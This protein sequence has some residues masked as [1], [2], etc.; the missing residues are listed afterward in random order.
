MLACLMSLVACSDDSAEPAVPE[1]SQENQEPRTLRYLALGD[2]YTIGTGL[3]DPQGAYPHQLF[4]LLD[5]DA[6]IEGK[7][8]EIIAQNGWTTAALSQGLNAAAPDSNFQLVS[9]LIGVNNQYQGLDTSIYRAEFDSLLERAIAHAQGNERQVF[10]LSIP[11]Y[12]LSPFASSQN[13]DP[14][15]TAEQIDR[16]NGMAEGMASARGVSFW[17]ITA[18]SRQLVADDAMLAADGLHPSAAQYA[19]WVEQI[20]ESVKSKIYEP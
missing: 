10:V 3:P 2:S 4:K 18:L 12:S 9:L 5:E 17:D 16:Y 20:V 11:D 6:M 19:Q 1:A 8:L 14:D 13:L 15:V 7:T